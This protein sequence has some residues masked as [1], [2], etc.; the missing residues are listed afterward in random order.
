MTTAVGKGNVGAGTGA[1][2]AEMKG[3][4]G[5]ASTV[6]PDGTVVATSAALTVPEAYPFAGGGQDGLALSVRPSHGLG[7]GDT[8]FSVVT[9][10]T[11]AG[12]C[13]IPAAEAPWA[14]YLTVALSRIR[15]L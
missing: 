13:G 7:D 10:A 15:Y 3:G 11:A 1:I 4:V 8:V 6:L 14:L 2:A 12:F 5:T 9:G